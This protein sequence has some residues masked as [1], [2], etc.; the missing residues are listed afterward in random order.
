MTMEKERERGSRRTELSERFDHSH[1]VLKR[2]IAHVETSGI[3]RDRKEVCPGQNPR[4]ARVTVGVS[5][6]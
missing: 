5:E 2:T 6:S 1:F 3:S 4:D